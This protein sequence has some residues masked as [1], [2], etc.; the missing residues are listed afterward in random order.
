VI[1]PMT[2]EYLSGR[3]MAQKI[4]I[5]VLLGERVIADPE[6]GFALYHMLTAA[7]HAVRRG[8]DAPD[9]AKQGCIKTLEE[10]LDAL[11][12]MRSDAARK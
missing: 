12:F 9:D 7:L 1:Q 3:I 8:K 4:L 6:D 11:E 5:H 2:A 10:A